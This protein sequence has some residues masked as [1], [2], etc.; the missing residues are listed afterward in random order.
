MWPGLCHG[1]FELSPVPGI[2]LVAQVISQVAAKAAGYQHVINRA[3]PKGNEEGRS[4]PCSASFFLLLS[5]P[6]PFSGAAW[7]RFSPLTL[8]S[9]TGE[10]K[11]EDVGLRETRCLVNSTGWEVKWANQIPP[12]FFQMDPERLPVRIVYVLH[13]ISA[14]RLRP[15]RWWQQGCALVHVEGFCGQ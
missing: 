14:H 8:G 13:V 6:P 5:S 7:S 2:H 15:A 12:T 3:T 11:E 10:E 1:G 4:L 9:V